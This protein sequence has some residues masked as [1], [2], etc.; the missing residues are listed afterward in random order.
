MTTTN[1]DD[2]RR[3]AVIIINANRGDRRLFRGI[4]VKAINRAL[5][6]ERCVEPHLVRYNVPEFG[7][8]A[9]YAFEAT[10]AEFAKVMD[11]LKAESEAAEVDRGFDCYH[12]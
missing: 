8:D 12:D 1:N 3:T 10:D 2:D 7:M 9:A 5:T 6:R 11:A 4:A